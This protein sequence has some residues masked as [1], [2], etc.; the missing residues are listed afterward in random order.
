MNFRYANS[1]TKKYRHDGEPVNDKSRLSF[2]R[3]MAE[4][5]QHEIA[6]RL[7]RAGFWNRSIAEGPPAPVRTLTR[8]E[9]EAEVIEIHDKRPPKVEFW[10]EWL[11]RIT[12]ELK[13]GARP[14]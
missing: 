11:K 2:D 10:G 5:A 8:A 12:S 6:D 4:I 14:W 9:I 13:L 7:Q 3:N 1:M